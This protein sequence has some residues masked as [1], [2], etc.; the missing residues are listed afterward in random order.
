MG[1]DWID[2][3][4]DREG[5]QAV[6]NAVMNFRVPKNGGISGLAEELLA[7]PGGLCSMELVSYRNV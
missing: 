7:S 2:L 3:N 5:W 6:V 1:M 4:H